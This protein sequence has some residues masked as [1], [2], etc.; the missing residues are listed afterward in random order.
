MP[1]Q[2]SLNFSQVQFTTRGAFFLLYISTG[3]GLRA[4]SHRLDMMFT[5]LGAN[6]WQR[7][8]KLETVAALPSILSG[9]KIAAGSA[10]IAPAGGPIVRP[11]SAHNTAG[12]DP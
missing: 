10:M 5:T 3:L 9:M 7:L 1:N 12:A 8:I 2:T 4:T 11:M 6:R